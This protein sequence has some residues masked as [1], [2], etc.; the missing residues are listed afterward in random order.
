VSTKEDFDQAFADVLE[1]ILGWDIGLSD[2]DGPGTVEGW[3][4][5]SHVRVIHALESR[6]DVRLP[7]EALLGE[8]TAGSLKQLIA[9]HLA[10]S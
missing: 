8:Q 9:D 3:D 2:D 5:L 4:S 10:G 6:F 7:D 1:E